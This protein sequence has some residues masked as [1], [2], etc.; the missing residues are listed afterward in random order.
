MLNELPV[1]FGSRRLHN[2]LDVCE[3][4]LEVSWYSCSAEF[5]RDFPVF[6]LH[7]KG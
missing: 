6:Y 5:G 3:A 4:C 2:Y 7:K 1:P